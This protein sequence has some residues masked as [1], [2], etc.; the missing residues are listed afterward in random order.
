MKGVGLYLFMAAGP[1]QE[2]MGE[3]QRKVAPTVWL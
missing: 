3:E 1:L 2:I